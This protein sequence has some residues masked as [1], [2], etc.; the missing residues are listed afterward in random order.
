MLDEEVV[1]IIKDIAL[2][3]Q[4]RYDIEI[5]AMGMDGNHIHILCSSH[6]K[7]SPGQIV[8]VFKSIT[9]REIFIKKPTVKKE[10]RD[11]E[12][13][14]DGYYVATVGERADW[15]TVEKY[16]KEARIITRRFETDTAVL[17]LDTL[18]SCRR[19]LHLR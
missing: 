14:S 5:E 4:E 17:E 1:E 18:W 8:R 19:I 10:L 15:G 7:I 12:F 2:G 6:P 13:W 11:G 9:A 16:I 3:I